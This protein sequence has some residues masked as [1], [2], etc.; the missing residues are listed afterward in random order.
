MIPMSYTGQ[1]YVIIVAFNGE[2]W[3]KT[4]LDSLINHVDKSHVIIVDNGSTDDSRNL[5]NDY[6]PESILLPQP[7]NLGF[8]R[9]NNI[10]ISYALQ[11]GAD[12]VFLI[13]QDAYLQ[14]QC[15]DR[16]IKASLKY[17]D[18]GILSPIHLTW[19][20][21]E[22]EHY[23]SRFALKNPKFYSDYVLGNPLESVY[24]VPFVNAAG[25]LLPKRSLEVIGGFDPM[26]FHYGEDNNYC[27]RVLYHGYKIG[28]VPSGFLCHDSKVRQEQPQ[29]LFSDIY[30]RDEVNKLQ[31]DLG[32]INK[33]VTNSH[34]KQVNRHVLK[35]I[36]LNFIRL[37]FKNAVGYLKKYRYFNRA[38]K[39]IKHSRDT[40]IVKQ[41]HYLEL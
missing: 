15:I 30:F 6:Y 7:S 1:L 19:K 16:L 24:E 36:F 2:R 18:Y 8:G 14:P 9:A 25:W 4:C 35:L 29:Y 13:N 27:Q 5:I 32:D 10:G 37:D 11:Q 39:N 17:P 28:I 26:F 23:F 41:A 33:K 38:F 22:L 34:Y 40:N 21:D 12:Y 31:I 20:G 3:L